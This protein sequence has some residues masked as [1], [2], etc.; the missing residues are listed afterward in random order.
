[1][2]SRSLCSVVGVCC[3][4]AAASA[5]TPTLNLLFERSL[6]AADG[7]VPTAS[8]GIRYARG[9]LDKGLLVA[10]GFELRYPA[11]ASINA[12]EGS[13]AFWIRP[14]WTGNDNDS[15]VFARWGTTGGG[16]I[17]L[18]DG[19]NNLRSIFNQFGAGGLPETGVGVNI[20]NWTFNTWHHVVFT[21]SSSARTVAMYVDGVFK[22]SAA[23][24]FNLPSIAA[25]EFSVGSDFGSS[26][27]AGTLDQFRIYPAALTL[28]Q[29]QAIYNADVPLAPTLAVD[30]E[31]TPT[32][33]RG[34]LP[35]TATNLTYTPGV[36]GSAGT[37]DAT[38]QLSY[39]ALNNLATP[40]GTLEFWVR[41]AFEGSD[42]GSYTFLGWGSWGGMLFARD[43]ASNLRGIFNRFGPSNTAEL[44]VGA[45]AADWTTDRWYHLAY[46]WDNT[47]KLLRLYVDGALTT[48]QAFTANLPVIGDTTFSIGREVFGSPFSGQLDQ[49]AIFNYPRTAEQIAAD[50]FADLSIQSISVDALAENP[51][52]TWQIWPR[53][54]GHTPVG[55]LTVHPAAV[56][57]ES[58]DPTVIAVEAP[59]TLRAVNPG[60][61]TLTAHFGSHT[62]ML[63]VTVATPPLAPD[64]P[65]IADYVATPALHYALEIPVISIRYLPTADGTLL[66]PNASGSAARVDETIA[67]IDAMEAE[68]KFMLE[69][70]SKFRGYAFPEARPMAGY[71]VVR[72]IN[73]FEPLPPDASLDHPSGTPGVWFPHY[74]SI[75]RRFDLA[76][77]INSQGVREIWLWGYHYGT[78]APVE[79]N[80][81]SP[82][83]GDISNSHRYADDL[84]VLDHTYILY[85]YNWDR[86]SNESVHDHGHQIE[87][88]LAHVAT[89]QDGNADLF[90]KSFTGRDDNG[91]PITGRCGNT[92]MPPNTTSDYDYANP[93]F[94]ASDIFNWSPAGGPT[95]DV[96][97][98][99]WGS[100]IYAWPSGNFP[101]AL[102]EHNWY[103]FWMQSIPGFDHTIPYDLGAGL[104]TN[105]MAAI[106]DWDHFIP[107]VTADFG[108]HTQMPGPAIE[109][110][111]PSASVCPGGTVVLTADRTPV[112][113]AHY[114]WRVNSAFLT[115]GPTGTGA[116]FSGAFTNQLT[117]SNFQAANTAEYQCVVVTALGSAST[118]PAPVTVCPGDF[119]C[120][121]FIDDI[122]FVLFAQQ[123]DLFDCSDPSIPPGC[124]ADL[125]IDG[126]VDDIDFVLFAQRYDLFICE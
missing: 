33:T 7:T 82:I 36:I 49:L 86:S 110:T 102:T 66:D 109:V 18:K 17:F 25:T 115:D 37:F 8:S 46:T 1:M 21:W 125:N 89:L 29:V 41:P 84:P 112:P 40:A 80:M 68:T 106:Y 97:A 95:Q 59:S 52:P 101:D 75:I 67:R 50:Y 92:H 16:M 14:D 30:F 63:P 60:I 104:I 118:S 3:V 98:D 65:P 51:F 99:T 54:V 26:L 91:Q 31:S 103:V 105:W 48:E 123:Y 19:A 44:G 57:W 85:N 96:N 77:L 11:A 100:L 2:P 114:R 74:D 27:A 94:A 126:F 122:D 108:L 93:A 53:V 43:G 120:D 42:P 81:S 78:I 9:F 56:Q 6:A 20:A 23:F 39:A 28:P 64:E 76:D 111:P 58:S 10:P 88:M 69:E 90:W 47:A 61:T 62:A 121:G 83:T 5:Q 15:H 35:L 22:S 117:I 70:G 116:V 124:S 72:V 79:S 45:S 71:R 119:N 73:V 13:I 12:T 4:A 38:T 107:A 55:T 87:S 113:A 34:E 32:G 24:N